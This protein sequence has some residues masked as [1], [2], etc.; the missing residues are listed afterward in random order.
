MDQQTSE[1]FSLRVILDTNVTFADPLLRS[2]L[3]QA[4]LYALIRKK[5]KLL[6]P[7]LIVHEVQKH[8]RSELPTQ[9]KLNYLASITGN[10]RETVPDASRIQ[11]IWT[12]RMKALGVV[13]DAVSVKPEHLANAAIRVINDRPPSET[14][15]GQVVDSAVWELVSELSRDHEVWVVTADNDYRSGDDLHPEL[16]AEVRQDS[17]RLF[18]DVS[19]CLRALKAGLPQFDFSKILPDLDRTCRT[20]LAGA[21][22]SVFRD[23]REPLYP[24][25]VYKKLPCPEIVGSV[26]P[27]ALDAYPTEDEDKECVTFQLEYQLSQGTSSATVHGAV[28][29][30]FKSAIPLGIFDPIV[31]DIHFKHLDLPWGEDQN[32]T[33]SC[34]FSLSMDVG[35][36][37]TRSRQLFNVNP[38]RPRVRP[39]QLP[40]IT[41]VTE[42][43]RELERKVA[44]LERKNSE[45]TVMWYEQLEKLESKKPE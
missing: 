30:D 12:S 2:A 14:K 19:S 28:G 33:I 10:R 34:E 42:R 43:E 26:S 29:Y 5:A 35:N 15:K 13:V 8:I 36:F 21:L 16:C 20:W 9:N 38:Y 17:V 41:G 4:L 18:R 31:S 11:S 6:Y 45:L 32:W 22:N 1:Q 44:D 25:Q 7:D 24:G 37:G 23:T 3:H 39:E 40:V 27:K